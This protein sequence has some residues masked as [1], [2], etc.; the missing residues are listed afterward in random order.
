[1]SFRAPLD[2][3]TVK[4]FMPEDEGLALYAA[5]MSASAGPMLEVGSYCGKSAV[6]LGA[7]AQ[8]RGEL[9][10]TIDH[11]RGSE[12]LQPGWAHHDPDTW[13]ARAGAIDTLPF[14]RDT[15]RRAGLESRVVPIVG[16]SAAIARVWSTRLAFLFIDGGHGMEPALA[17]YRGW[18]VHVAPGGLMAIHDVFPDPKDGGRPPYE[19]YRMALASGAFVEVSAI[20]SLRILRRS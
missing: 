15:L 13:D 14:L 10:F 18:S 19:I 9:L 2:L 3:S 17:D 12:E 1:M 8:A 4:G 5:A 16:Q 7:A 20:G 11:H 6:Y